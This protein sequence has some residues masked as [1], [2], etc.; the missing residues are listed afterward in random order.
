MITLTS[1]VS[2]GSRGAL[3]SRHQG[4]RRLRQQDLGRAVAVP[5]SD[6][7]QMSVVVSERFKSFAHENLLIETR[8]G[9]SANPEA[10]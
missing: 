9:D 1:S 8:E 6:T 2:S 10:I 3:T 5:E 7:Q 4:R